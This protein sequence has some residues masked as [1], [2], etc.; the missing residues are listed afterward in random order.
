MKEMG[1][2]GRAYLEKYLVRENSVK[3]YMEEILS[4]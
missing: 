3:K 4:C 2:R 1:A